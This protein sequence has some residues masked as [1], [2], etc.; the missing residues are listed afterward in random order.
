VH[1]LSSPRKTY[2]L[3]DLE[4]CYSALIEDKRLYL[5]GIGKLQ[6]FEVTPLLDEPLIPVAKIPTNGGPCGVYKILRVGDDLL[7]G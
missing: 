7:L 6:I 1:D 2:N 3:G 4:I 5:G